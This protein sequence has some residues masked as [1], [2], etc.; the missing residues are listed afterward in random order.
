MSEAQPFFVGVS[1]GL[2][3]R[4]R[5][6]NCNATT[7]HGKRCSKKSIWLSKY[8]YLH[9]DP[10]AWIIGTA[11]GVLVT[12][13]IAVYQTREPNISVRC[14]TNEH[15][16]P[17]KLVC[18]V[19]NHG[20]GEAKDIYVA[21][22]EFIPI[23]TEVISAPEV[24]AKLIPVKSPPDPNL[25]P[26][27]S[28]VTTAF[29]IYIPRVSAKDSVNFTV[30]TFNSD[31]I[32]TAKH[33]LNIKGET[34]HVLKA[35]GSLLSKK[36]PVDYKIWD[37]Q[38]VLSMWIKRANFFNPYK[39]SYSKGRFDVDFISD[40][41]ITANAVN[42]DF[43]IEHKDEF[44]EIFYKKDFIMPIIKYISVNGESTYSKVH[45]YFTFCTPPLVITQDIINLL[46]SGEVL[47]HNAIG[48][49][50]DDYEIGCG[51]KKK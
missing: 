3:G 22:T 1:G 47:N 43:I 26:N 31:N 44:K 9:Q 37:M 14:E 51:K 7:R 11:L 42:N 45:P 6:M 39:Y 46:N 29:S 12:I 21:F 32:K 27:S 34:E 28:K 48:V 4:I 5:F 13:S 40:F 30:Q 19:D 33:T 35:V 49:V 25:N 24:N 2:S 50:P 23:D 36:Y 16:S 15:G 20:R 18:Y 10:T 38:G 41:E 8:C 17:D